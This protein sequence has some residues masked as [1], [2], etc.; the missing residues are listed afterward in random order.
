MDIAH[1][2][3]YSVPPTNKSTSRRIQ[4]T[5]GLISTARYS[6]YLYPLARGIK[7]GFT[8]AAGYCLISSAEK[9]HLSLISVVLGSVQDPDTK[10][11]GHF[12]DT[13]TLFEWGFENF[14]E[15][16]VLSR[17]EPVSKVAVLRGIGKDEV[18][19]V[20]EEEI[21]ALVPKNL[22]PNAVERSVYLN[23][24][25]GLYAPVYK[26]EILGTVTLAMEGHVYGTVNLLASYT[27]EE[28]TTER[29]M[30][31]IQDWFRKPW[32][33]WVWIG[34]GSALALWIFLTIAINSHKRKERT[35]KSMHY[36]GRR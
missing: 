26:D 4:T 32:L 33:K 9:D 29:M 5:N 27:V 11:L 31:T 25:E 30:D 21:F 20:P 13:K 36:R 2:D 28:D 23:H 7:T 24:P 35:K 12:V 15:K 14:V 3:S 22:D 8:N 17:N 16:K 19:L 10:L 34:L 6:E 1:T 18:T